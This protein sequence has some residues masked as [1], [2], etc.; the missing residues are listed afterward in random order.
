MFSFSASNTLL[1]NFAIAL[2]SPFS[3]ATVRIEPNVSSATEPASAY[4]FCAQSDLIR[5]V[6]ISQ[7]NEMLMNGMTHAIT[8]VIS[9]PRTKPMTKPT[10][11]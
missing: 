10:M 9:H 6:L 5:N 2:C 3:D 8:N 11:N 1:S 7:P 4:T